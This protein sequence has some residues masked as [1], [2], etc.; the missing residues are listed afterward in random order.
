[1]SEEQYKKLDRLAATSDIPGLKG[2]VETFIRRFRN[3]AFVVF[4]SPIILLCTFCIG[5][6]LVPGVYLFHFVYEWTVSFSQF[7]HFLSLAM[8]IAFGYV[9]YGFSLIFIV[10]SVNFILPIRV[11]KWRGIWHSIQS[12]PWYVHNALTYI[13]RYTFLEFI[14]PSPLN[15]LFYRMMGMKI[16][17]GVVINTTNISDPCMIEL[18][19][20]VTVGGS[21]HIFAHYGQKG[22]LI[23]APVT[24]KKGATIGLKA[25]IMGDVIV[26]E[27]ALVKPHTV[28]LPKTRILDGETE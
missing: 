10:P 6:A 11:K 7:F 22:I 8:S 14:T 4:L 27:K 18:E 19:D 21:A 16:G 26:G 17:K 12:I 3:L 23:I 13:V 15:I 24:I 1:M 9:L 28:L 20:Y 5:L 2:L 25:S